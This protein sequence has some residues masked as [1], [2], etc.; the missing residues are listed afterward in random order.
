MKTGIAKYDETRIVLVPLKGLS[1]QEAL[2][3]Q[4]LAKEHG[5]SDLKIVQT[6]DVHKTK[7]LV[8]KPKT[9]R[10]IVTLQT[11]KGH[12]FPDGYLNKFDKEC[13]ELLG[14]YKEGEIYKESLTTEELDIKK[15]IVETIREKEERGEYAESD[16]IAEADDKT[17]EQEDVTE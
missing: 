14:E 13:N 11:L 12:R 16:A 1:D 4:D 9:W 6:K 2:S 15:K 5:W 8:L 7:C 10:H 17:W 3:F